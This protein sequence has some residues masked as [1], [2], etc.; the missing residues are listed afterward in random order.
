[1]SNLGK[2]FQVMIPLVTAFLG[3]WWCSLRSPYP[4]TPPFPLSHSS[5][6]DPHPKKDA[7]RRSDLEHKYLEFI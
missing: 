7:D 3:V 6:V 5:T 1:M 2:K 4:P